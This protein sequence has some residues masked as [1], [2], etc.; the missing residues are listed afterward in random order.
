MKLVLC[1]I[2]LVAAKISS[3]EEIIEKKPVIIVDPPPR[4]EPKPLPSN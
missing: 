1:V 4:P 2:W 3:C